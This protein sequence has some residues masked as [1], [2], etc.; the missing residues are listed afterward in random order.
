MKKKTKE[1]SEKKKEEER[2]GARKIA[3]ECYT[4]KTKTTQVQVS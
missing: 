2:K 4:P 1:K 3:E